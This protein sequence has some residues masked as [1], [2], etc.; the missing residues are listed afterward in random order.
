MGIVHSVITAVHW[1]DKP[2]GWRLDPPISMALLRQVSQYANCKKTAAILDALFSRDR[3][4][5][6][7]AHRL[8]THQ[9]SAMRPPMFL[10]NC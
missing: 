2:I 8:P 1:R 4:L 7:N 5:C 6:D 3:C 10:L 9:I